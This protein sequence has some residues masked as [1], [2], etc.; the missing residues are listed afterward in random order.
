M[1]VQV[2]ASYNCTKKKKGVPTSQV[3]ELF[4]NAYVEKCLKCKKEYRRDVVTPNL[5][6]SFNFSYNIYKVEYAM[7]NNAK[8]V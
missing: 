2:I 4:G 3:A 1:C 8:V 7:M 5:G 6:T